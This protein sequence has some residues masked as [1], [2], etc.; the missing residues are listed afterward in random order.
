MSLTTKEHD[1][2]QYII[3]EHIKNGGHPLLISWVAKAMHTNAK[4]VNE[5]IIKHSADFDMT[6]LEVMTNHMYVER[7]RMA[8][9]VQPSHRCLVKIIQGLRKCPP[10]T[11]SLPA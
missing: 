1:I 7:Y 10:T 5:C 9:A 2:C 4:T 8:P 6:E 11:N 3:D